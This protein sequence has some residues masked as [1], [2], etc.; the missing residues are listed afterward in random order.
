M[1]H[2]GLI[3]KGIMKDVTISPGSS[4]SMKT[5]FWKFR[6]SV[7]AYA[8]VKGYEHWPGV[9]ETMEPV[10]QKNGQRRVQTRESMQ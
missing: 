8:A 9:M 1:E 5:E 4:A 2:K 6:K 10:E 7:A 3:T